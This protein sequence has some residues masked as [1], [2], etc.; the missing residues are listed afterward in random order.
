MILNVLLFVG[1]FVGGYFLAKVWPSSR[2]SPETEYLIVTPEHLSGE[3]L[4]T[5]GA[6]LVMHDGTKTQVLWPVPKGT[7]VTLNKNRP[8]PIYQSGPLVLLENDIL[9]SPRAFWMSVDSINGR[10]LMK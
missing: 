3:I 8:D 1:S 2:K 5:A 9:L 6:K 10:R 4:P 7:K